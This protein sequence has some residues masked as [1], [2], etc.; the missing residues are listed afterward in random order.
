[1]V[2]SGL[3]DEPAQRLTHLDRDVI[4]SDIKNMCRRIKKKIEKDRERLARE[5]LIVEWHEPEA[6]QPL[7]Y[8]ENSRIKGKTT[9]TENPNKNIGE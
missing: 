2:T 3:N 7:H 1:M 4:R 8:K 6:L 5:N 9:C